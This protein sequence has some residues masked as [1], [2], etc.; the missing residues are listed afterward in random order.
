MNQ[1]CPGE[2]KDHR[3]LGWLICPLQRLL[4]RKSDKPP[5]L[6]IISVATTSD[7]NRLL[8]S[9]KVLSAVG[10]WPPYL[11]VN[12]CI[13]RDDHDAHNS[14]WRLFRIGWRYDN[15]WKGYIGPSAAW[16]KVL[17]P[18]TYY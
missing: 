16:K 9:T 10:F 13:A 17:W 6:H 3:T 8:Y 1:G 18:L 11:V 15:N 7:P 12:A 4:S 2:G 5:R 14:L